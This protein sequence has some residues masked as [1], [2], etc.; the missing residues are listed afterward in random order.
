MG[1]L[2]KGGIICLP[3]EYVS[4]S[5]NVHQTPERNNQWNQVIQWKPSRTDFGK[6]KLK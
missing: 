1:S 4:K 5:S 3:V 6:C 2:E